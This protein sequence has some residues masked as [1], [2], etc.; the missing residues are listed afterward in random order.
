MKG[1]ELDQ[2]ISSDLCS[3]IFHHLQLR[4][5]AAER[6]G[7]QRLLALF[8]MVREMALMKDQRGTRY[9]STYAAYRPGD[10]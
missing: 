8:V 1:S 3:L 9:V 10:R 6:E 4:H 7:K 2:Y 5:Y